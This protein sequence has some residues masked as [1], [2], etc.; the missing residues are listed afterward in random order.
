MLIGRVTLSITGPWEKFGIKDVS[1][2]NKLKL[3]TM[4]KKKAPIKTAVVKT[5]QAKKVD[6]KIQGNTSLD[7]I[8]G[9]F[10]DEIPPDTKEYKITKNIEAVLMKKISKSE[11]MRGLYRIQITNNKEIAYWTKSHPSFVATVIIK[12][13]RKIKK[14]AGN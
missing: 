2:W 11:K 5:E 3:K 9:Q 6:I 14:E 4:T 7:P 13:K 8:I 12:L 1:L 10:P